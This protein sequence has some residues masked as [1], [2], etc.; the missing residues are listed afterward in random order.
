M[1]VIDICA[2]HQMAHEEAQQA[3]D[4]LA[5]DLARKFD[6]DYGWDGDVIHFERHGASG[7]ISVGRREIRINARLGFFLA[8]LKARIEDEIKQ[9]L[10]SHFNCTFEE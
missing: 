4:D 3:A 9:Y 6:I 8:M 2:F 7:S 10:E 1:S 5:A